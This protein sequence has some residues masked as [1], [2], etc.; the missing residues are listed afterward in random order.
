LKDS[1]TADELK[2]QGE[3]SDV[4]MYVIF[5]KPISVVGE[6]AVLNN[7]GIYVFSEN[8]ALNNITFVA[9]KSLGDLINVGASNVNL[10]NL[11]ITY[12]VGDEM[13]NTIN[14]N[15]EKTISNVN[16]LNNNIYFESHVSDDEEMTTA[17]NL[18]NVED[19]IVGGN[20]IVANIPA[21][22]V[23]TYDYTYFMMGLCYVNPIRIYES[24]DVE[25]S[26]NKIDVTVNDFEDDYPTVQALYVVG[27]ESIMIGENNFT[28]RDTLTPN[29]T[30]IYLYA[31]ECGFSS[32]V[33]FIENNFDILTTGGKS[34]LG[35]AY[36]LQIATSDALVVGN[37]IIC[38][39]NGP[40]LGIYSPYGFGPAKDL[41]ITDNFINVSGYAAGTSDYALVSGIEVQTG[42]ATIYN[43]TIY[44]QN[45][46]AY[47]EKYPVAGISAIQYSAKT[48]TFD[49]QDNEIYTN[50]KYA[51]QMIYAPSK[52]TV[53]GNYLLS[54]D[55]QGDKSVSV[56]SG[57]SITVENNRPTNVVTNDTFFDFFDDEGVL[58]TPCV[59]KELIFNGTFSGLVDVITITAPV[60]IVGNDAVLNDI[61]IK[62]TA[63]NVKLTSLAV[64]ANSK[65]FAKN[66]GALIYVA[67]SNVKI[68]DVVVNYT[69]PASA[70][71]IA[72]Y[73]N[74]ADNFTMTNS[75]I[76]YVATNPGDKHN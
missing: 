2:F 12:I 53:T 65:E 54:Y 74:A 67:A 57:G 51:V 75:E 61:A 33:A 44:V 63:D 68:T 21:L 20:V 71:A 7:M 56:K 49:I 59:F 39:S 17:I 19:V 5:D 46:G 72:V 47:G 62:V 48:L 45:K 6:N 1:V 43:N 22:Y 31:V 8:V 58:L 32:A 42:Y 11:D 14:V 15:G 28:M 40:N 70:E 25:L 66:E 10:T 38:D 30:A 55:L 34:G 36:A 4:S 16:I 13:A 52:T 18:D 64:N 69:A 23:A 76:A 27:S 35:S 41:I 60:S 26:N 73:A 3:F 9:T 37:T 29:G 24:K 50:G